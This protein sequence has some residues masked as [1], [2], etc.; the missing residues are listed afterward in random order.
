VDQYVRDEV[1]YQEAR[2]LGLDQ[3]DIIVRRRLIQKVE[4]LAEQV[5]AL[6]EPDDETLQAYLEAHRDRY[7]IPGR[8]SF[9][10]LYF[11]RELRGDRAEAE[12]R[13]QLAQLQAHPQQAVTSDRSMLPSHFTL[14]SAPEIARVF[15]EAFA[16]QLTTLT[17]TGWQ[18]PFSSAYGTHL[19]KVTEVEPGHDAQL[20]EVRHDVRLD[21][22]RDQQLAQNEAFYQEL[23]DRYTIQVDQQALAAAVTEVT[24]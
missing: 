7:V 16:T 18:G 10:Q 5:A 4:F 15:G 19:V 8:V 13:Q 3:N 14:A 6:Q 1:F 17:K 24:P 12:A 21:W 11:S 20:A 22:L 23:R 2:A 9:D